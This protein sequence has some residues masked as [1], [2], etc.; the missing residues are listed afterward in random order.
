[1]GSGFSRVFSVTGRPTVVFSDLRGEPPSD[2]A[3]PHGPP[4]PSHFLSR[5]GV[6]LLE[7]VRRRRH[8]FRTDEDQRPSRAV[9][10]R[11][12]GDGGAAPVRCGEMVLPS[13]RGRPARR[14]LM[15]ATGRLRGRAILGS[16]GLFDQLR[17]PPGR[18]AAQGAIPSRRSFRE[19]FEE[20]AD[21]AARGR[22]SDAG[23]A[24]PAIPHP[25]SPAACLRTRGGGI[26]WDSGPGGRGHQP[27]AVSA[28]RE[29]SR[30]TA[31]TLQGAG[32]SGRP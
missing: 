27:R 18:A 26:T 22:S 6:A 30:S 16:V 21:A 28:M 31:F 15:F 1:L 9:R 7:M 29:I 17:E 13:P 23:G 8:P 24:P 20:I 2:R 32:G 14:N 10:A 25:P 4:S 19:L 11:A 3:P 5:P 12:N